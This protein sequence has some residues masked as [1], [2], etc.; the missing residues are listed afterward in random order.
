[1]II[2]KFLGRTGN[3]IFQYAF[4]RILADNINVS[5]HSKKI[6]LFPHAEIGSYIENSTLEFKNS[7]IL[8]KHRVNIEEIISKYKEKDI[9][10]TEGYFQRAEYYLSHEEKIKKWLSF[11]KEYQK[12]IKEKY[13]IDKK[14]LGIHVRLGDYESL[15]YVIKKDHL[16][17]VINKAIDEEN[18][19]NRIIVVTND[20]NNS[21]HDLFQKYKKRNID[22]QIVKNSAKED[23]YLLTAFDNFI[24]SQSSFSW[25]ASFFSDSKNIFC[26]KTKTYGQWGI[27]NKP[28]IDLFYYK[29]KEVSCE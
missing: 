29:I 1:M 16:E 9:I 17:K 22:I 13:K 23:F 25:W 5:F 18:S 21:Y 6:D 14:C 7:K 8:K 28:D 27:E 26:P 2:I 19:I 12:Q 4:S 3:N 10:V 24:M 15:G 11:D 20:K